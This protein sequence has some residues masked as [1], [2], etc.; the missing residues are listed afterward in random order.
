MRHPLLTAPIGRSL[1]RL[2]GPTTALM[3]MQI[4]VAVTDVYFVSRLGTEPLAGTALVLPFVTLMMNIANG[5]MGGSV[6]AS[7]ARALGASVPL[8]ERFQRI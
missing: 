4:F 7:M 6:A 5:A 2:A 8:L 3:L 1:L